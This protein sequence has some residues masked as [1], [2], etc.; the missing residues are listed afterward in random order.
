MKK[1]QVESRK[2]FF[3]EKKYQKTSARYG[4]HPLPMITLG[5]YGVRVKVFCFFFSKKKP[6]FLSRSPCT[7]L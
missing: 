6:S 2:Q 7:C 3:F 5:R 1:M 4:R